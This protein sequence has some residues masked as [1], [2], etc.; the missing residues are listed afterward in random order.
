MKKSILASVTTLLRATLLSAALATGLLAQAAEGTVVYHINDNASASALLV[1]VGN[2]LVA[3]PD[4]RIHVVSHGR[5]IDFLLRDARDGNGEAYAYRVKALAEKG[6]Q[7]KVCRNTLRGRKLDDN[8]VEV[9][10]IVVPAG[11]V[12]IARLQLEEK[13]AYIKP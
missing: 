1:N 4:N 3:A 13:A 8:A 10:V 7:F 6:V 9:G 11:V 5:G 2:H 12:E